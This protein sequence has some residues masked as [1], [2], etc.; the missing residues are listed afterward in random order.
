MWIKWVGTVLNEDSQ[1]NLRCSV[2]PLWAEASAWSYPHRDPVVQL[3]WCRLW[4]AGAANGNISTHSDRASAEVWL[5]CNHVSLQRWQS[6]LAVIYC[7]FTCFWHT[8]VIFLIGLIGAKPFVCCV[9]DL[10]HN[11]LKY[12][13]TYLQWKGFFFLY[14]TYLHNTR[15]QPRI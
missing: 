3:L 4:S 6:S 12:S 10:F 1:M 8:L 13:L 2:Q 5:I 15:N 14:F 9:D 11:L 7:L